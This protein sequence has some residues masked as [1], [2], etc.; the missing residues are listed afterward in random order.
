[1]SISFHV[2]KYSLSLVLLSV[3]LG[4]YLCVNMCTRHFRNRIFPPYLP[5]CV[6]DCYRDY[7]CHLN[8]PVL[9]EEVT[10]IRGIQTG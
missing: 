9:F 1:M 4:L 5:T 6:F 8:L 2:L 7:S 3:P 10:T